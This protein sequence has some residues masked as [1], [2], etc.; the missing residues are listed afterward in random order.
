MSSM[1]MIDV[2]PGFLLAVLGSVFP[3][4]VW[5]LVLLTVRVNLKAWFAWVTYCALVCWWLK[6]LADKL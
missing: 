4:A 1:D 3:A 2:S 5:L 6:W